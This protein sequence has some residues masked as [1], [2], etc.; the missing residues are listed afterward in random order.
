MLDTKTLKKDFSLFQNE[1][2]KDLIYLDNSAT[3]QTPDVVAEAETE[4]YR[5]YRANVNRG[6]Y[7][8]SQRAS[9]AYDEA[10]AKVAKFIN[11]DD[12]EIIFTGGAT[13]SSN[14]LMYSLEN[15][16]VFQEGDEIITTMMEH[17]SVLVPLQ[18]LAKRKKL[19]LRIIP[20]LAEKELDYN[21]A[22][23]FITKK[24]KLVACIG[25][26]NVTGTINNMKL[27]S[28]LAR[29]VGAYSLIDATQAAGHIPVDVKEIGCDFLFFS[30]HKM[31]GPTG[32]GVLYG[33]KEILDKLTPGNFG[34]G[35]VEEVFEE[36]AS[37]ALTPAKFEAGT[38]NIAGAIGL[39]VACEYLEKIG[40]GNIENHIQ[41][42]TKYALEELSKVDGV[43]IYS[44][45]NPEKNIGVISFL[46]E[47][48]HPHDTSE[49][50][51]RFGVA[52]RAG[53]HCAQPLVKSMG[54]Y[55][56]TRA[57]M[58]FYNSKEDVDGLIAGIGEVKK[59]FE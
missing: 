35:M 21:E 49:I 52:T 59:V 4:Y 43:K 31:C 37:Y 5:A 38:P 18:E 6:L 51:A 40:V 45:T 53:H 23:K 33:K 16:G 32:I 13:D 30:G 46:I 47:G 34:G 57:S 2:Q 9:K 36:E 42:V 22:E 10:R 27:L 3:S 1:E 56:V 20:M 14:L 17:H 29:K 28:D 39:G 48:A 41:E 26:S 7:P 58:Y 24:T 8:L 55:A 15:S 11:A 44:Q 19:R 25:V 12:R 54:V 50:L